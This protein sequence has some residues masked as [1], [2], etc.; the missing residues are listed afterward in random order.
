MD[1]AVEEVSFAGY[2][3]VARKGRAD[4][5]KGGVLV[6]VRNALEGC[7]AKL[8]E[9]PVADR[10]WASVHTDMGPLCLLLVQTT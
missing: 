6:L 7:I 1:P 2:K 10:V 9:S 5:E 3:E 4:Q 8:G